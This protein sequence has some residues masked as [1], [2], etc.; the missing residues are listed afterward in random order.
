MRKFSQ[1]TIVCNFLTEKDKI[2]KHLE[3]KLQE[4][5]DRIKQLKLE[6]NAASQKH[7]DTINQL[8]EVQKDLVKSETEAKHWKEK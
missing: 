5:D 8:N 1:C 3:T 7:Q 6:L 4:K 2:I